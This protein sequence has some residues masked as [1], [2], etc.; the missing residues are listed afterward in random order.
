LLVGLKYKDE[1]FEKILEADRSGSRA[2]VEGLLNSGKVSKEAAILEILNPAMIK[3]G[4]E[5]GEKRISLSQTF[6][7]A[8]IAEDIL[9]L[10]ATES[11]PTAATKG[12]VVIGNI[13]DD[14]HG[15][16]RRIVTSYLRS[17]GW[18]VHD[19]GTDVTPAR[20]L[21]TAREVK[22]QI[23]GASAMM[24][25]TALN[26]CRLREAIDNSS[27]AGK[28]KLA[29]GG[30]VFNWRP[31]LVQRVGADGTAE[32]AIEVDALCERLLKELEQSA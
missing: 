10:C 21:K 20:F 13:E 5:W 18:E 23:I 1:L 14:F 28:V 29:V 26:I 6:V 7:A 31:Q 27:L 15:L 32:T 2:F 22:A 12:T 16:G 19:L 25:T 9:A 17:T 24:Q 11:E 4:R 30:A 3:V 8:K